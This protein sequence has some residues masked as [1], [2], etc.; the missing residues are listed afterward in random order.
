M[1]NPEQQ[2]IFPRAN[3]GLSIQVDTGTDRF[4]GKVRDLS[5]EGIAFTVERE[6]PMGSRVEVEFNLEGQEIRNNL[7]KVEVLRCQPQENEASP[8][9]LISGKLIDVND[10]Y[11][12]DVLALIFGRRT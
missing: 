5:I 7:V 8:S 10:V 1:D 3:I 2:R 6:L 12:N 11:L 4:P 9:F